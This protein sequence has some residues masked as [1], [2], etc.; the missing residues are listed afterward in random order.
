M[1]FT[2][3]VNSSGN[4]SL[5]N[6]DRNLLRIKEKERRN[7]EAHQEKETFSEKVPLFGEPYKTDKGDEL[8][9]RLQNMLGNYEEVKEFLSSKSHPQRLDASENRLA[10]PRYPLFPEKGSSIPSHSFH[11]SVHHQPVNTPAS[12]PL[13]VGNI[14]HNPK[15]AQPR[16]EP[17]PSLHVKSY[18][19]QDGQH[20]T[21][22]RLGQEGY[23]SGHPKKGDRRAD[24]DHCAS[25]TDSAPERALSPLFSSLPSPVP[26]LSP[27]HSNQQ[28]LPRTQ[29][30]SKVH[31]SSSNNKGYCPAKSPKDPVGKG[32][33]KETPQDSS[34]AV[35]SL[36]VAPPQPPS[37]TFPPPPLPSKSVAMQQKP[38]AYVRPMDG[39]DQ[40][41]SESP[42]L[43]PLPE[44]YR[45]QTF[46]KTDLK[47]PAKAKLTK[48]KMPS[49]SV[50]TYSSEVH[51]VEEI[52]KEMTHSWPPP[53]TAI[54]TPST[55]EPSKFPFPTK[56]SQHINSAT[57]NQKQYDTSSKTHSNSQQGTSMLKDDLQLSDSEDS[58]SDQ[59]PEKPPSTS[60]PPSAPQ[61]LPEAAASAHSSSAESE[62]TSDS[63]SSSDSESESSSSDS[64]ENEPREAP[65]PEPEPPTVNKWQLDNWLTKVSQPAVP[66]E[67]PGGAEPPARHPDGKAKGGDGATAGHERSECKEPP[68]RSSSKAPRP[69]P[70]EG[71][72]AGK[73]GCQKSPAQQEPPQRQTVGTKRAGKASAPAGTRACL[74]VEGEPGLPPHGAK[75]QPSKDKPKVKTKG[76]PRAGESREPK[77]AVP[78]PSERKKHRSGPPGPP[79]APARDGAE[80]RSPEH[81]A[82]VPV[83]QS[84]GP[85]RGAG[86]RTSGCRLAV[87]VQEDRRKDKPLV[88]VR[89]PR[90]RSP[91]RE[92][93]PPRSLMVK[94]TLDL[95]SRIPQ[96]PGKVGRQKKPEYKPPSAG[97]KLDSEKK[98]SDN[99]S[100]LAKKRKGEAERDHDSKKVKLE[101]DVKSQSS[102]SS[103]HK[104]SSKS[105]TPRPSS[106]PSKKEMLPPS[107]V[108]SSSSSSS[109]SSQKPAKSAPKRPRQEADSCGQDAPK[110]AS[111]TKGNHKDTSV[112]K[113]R[114]AE[115]KG[116]GS[117][118][119]HRGSSGDTANRFPVPSLPNGN[120]KPGKPHMKLDKQQADFHMKEAKRLKDKAEL[121]TDK[122]GKAFKYLEAALSFIE[123]GIAMESEGPASRSAYSIYSETVDLIKFIMSLKSFSDATTPTQEKIFAVLCMRCQ[124]ILNMA[125]FR[126]K[127]D[128]A[129]KYSR[130]LNE[131]FFKTSSK[132]TQAPSP[133]V[134]RSTGTPSPLS[135]MPSPAGSGGSQPSAGSAGSSGLPPA[136]S[137][138]VTIQNMTSSYVTI[139]SHVLTAFDL[140]EQAEVL[141]QK[142]KEFFA[143]LSTSVCTLALNSSL[144]DLVHYTR[145]GFQRLKQVTKTP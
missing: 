56:D 17:M 32:H 136:V 130:T 101:K 89:D 111:S 65:A 16:M 23:G 14:S 5:Y 47:V 60:A 13:P 126:C 38:T 118:A 3:R 91:L 120:S 22:E 10:K 142:N 95:L 75:D 34:V 73:R 26:P 6:E 55:A 67:V 113:H 19:P 42:E 115:G 143:Q 57:Q 25:M 134:A 70:S 24:G 58:D 96:P 51:C 66:P 72:H 123:C 131:H 27:V 88:P 71:P 49:Q 114:K 87:V 36:G 124:S 127:K 129:I 48:L 2:E 11:S 135:P 109:S 33:D 84:Q 141:T 125:M 62:S 107:L 83:T 92:P 9:S 54:H 61:P 64:E 138:P 145:Q 59:T 20:L 44:D 93:P 97:K 41:P 99:P 63:D 139:T 117:S 137:T 18:G 28:T 110:S 103:S 102:S 7:Q 8:S 116:S 100:R 112:S 39:Q 85:A 50:E 82:L 29:G 45:P 105:K 122:V 12:G 37:Q 21:Q 106:E 76:R 132:V 15:M 78:A 77:P 79:K 43:K 35:A 46:E 128:I 140:W 121:M 74:Q 4:S 53:L 94:I 108:S 40:A 133:C 52:L 81:F 30:S 119:E 1:A 144:M 98:G 80:D 90:Q 31:S 68:P 69:P 104:D 86:A